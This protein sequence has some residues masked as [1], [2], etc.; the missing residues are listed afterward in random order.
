[1]KNVQGGYIFLIIFKKLLFLDLMENR[2]LNIWKSLSV[3]DENVRKRTE[4]FYSSTT[5]IG[6]GLS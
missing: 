4:L 5:V 1:M 3:P 2:L 6:K